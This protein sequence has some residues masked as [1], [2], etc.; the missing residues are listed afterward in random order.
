MFLPPFLS[1]HYKPCDFMH[2]LFV[3]LKYVAGNLSVILVR[4]AGSIFPVA[5]TVYSVNLIV[6]SL[7]CMLT[8]A[9]L[10]SG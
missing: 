6:S 7:S 1:F 4:K 5:A 3:S 10:R 9:L 8:G 2:L